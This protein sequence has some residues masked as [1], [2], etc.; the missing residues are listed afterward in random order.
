MLK[1]AQHIDPVV[2]FDTGTGNK[3][4]LLNIEQIVKVE[5]SDLCLALPALH[6]FTRCDTINAFVRR[7]KITPLKVLKKF[8]EFMDVLC[9]LGENVAVLQR[10]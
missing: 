9:G 3:R 10:Y 8:P 6:C 7:G 5:G 4:R 2:L 1:Y